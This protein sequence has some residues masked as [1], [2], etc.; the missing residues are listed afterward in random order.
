MTLSIHSDKVYSQLGV[1]IT[2]TGI[3]QVDSL[4]PLLWLLN[5][6]AECMLSLLN[7]HRCE[8]RYIT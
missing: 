8:R 2:V 7:G 6:S 4:E 3:A 5:Q 1:A